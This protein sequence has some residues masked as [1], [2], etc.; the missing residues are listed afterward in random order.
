MPVVVGGGCAVHCTTRYTT[1]PCQGRLMQPPWDPSRCTPP[2]WCV[3]HHPLQRHPLSPLD[4]P[5]PPPWPLSVSMGIICHM[6][7][8]GTWQHHTWLFR[9]TALGLLG[10]AVA[11]KDRVSRAHEHVVHTKA[12]DSL[13]SVCAHVLQD[14]T[15]LQGDVDATIA[16]RGLEHRCGRFKDDAAVQR[17]AGKPALEEKPDVFVCCQ[18]VSSVPAGKRRPG[19]AAIRKTCAPQSA[20]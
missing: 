17:K 20:A 15:L 16:V 7:H 9:R 13:D 8:V 18:E 12:V 3:Q 5:W 19:H 11:S 1:N 4:R 6:L 10:P 2:R 14:S